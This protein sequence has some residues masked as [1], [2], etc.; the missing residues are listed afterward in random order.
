M[1]EQLLARAAR[2]VA[3]RAEKVADTLVEAAR[4]ELPKDVDMKREA[5]AIVVQGKALAQRA[6]T[7]LAL[8]GLSA[9]AKAILK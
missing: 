4:A 9:L 5:S 7:D 8:R 3:A 2:I 1:M 6:L